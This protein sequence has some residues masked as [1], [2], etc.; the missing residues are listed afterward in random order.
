MASIHHQDNRAG[1]TWRVRW[2]HDG[3]QESLSFIDET[4]AKRFKSNVETHGHEQAMRILEIEDASHRVPTLTEFLTGHVNE[5]TGVQPATIDRYRRYIELDIAP[6]PMGQLPITAITEHSIGNWVK[7]LEERLDRR[8]NLPAGKTIK[9][10]HGF[11]S[12][13]FNVAVK[14]GVIAAN[15]CIGRRLPETMRDEMV[16]L[17]AD[18]FWLLHSH[19]PRQIWQN[20]ATWLVLTGMRFSEATVLTAADIDVR[21]RTCRINKAW[22]YA[23]NRQGLVIGPPKTKKSN[24]TI[25]LPQA[26]LDVID[27]SQPEWLFANGAGSPIRAQEFFNYG[28]KPGRAAAQAAGLT[29]SPR[30]HDLRHTC[31]SWLIQA[32][33][34]LPVIQ[35]QLGHES[36][37]TT[38][39]T[40]GHLDRRAANAAAA[41][42]DIAMRPTMPALAPAPASRS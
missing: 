21:A 12:G 25:S 2:R 1:R 36:I 16:F 34:P 35:Q 11:L 28:W 26:A 40:Y 41:A 15:P 30:V 14:T 31:A 13:A 38:V 32:G 6:H 3:R 22:K 24:R 18:E 29:K 33:I 20:L 5:L 19:L 39:G 9:N 8:G 10:K 4:G 27:L 7:D 42:L 23:T 37:M 17:T